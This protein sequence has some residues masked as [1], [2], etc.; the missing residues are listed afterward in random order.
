MNDEKRTPK[1]R[2]ND[3]IDEDLPE[4]DEEVAE[5]REE[6][7]AGEEEYDAGDGGEEEEYDEEPEPGEKK[8]HKSGFVAVVGLPNA[9]KST[10]VNRFL[11]E[12]ITIVSPKPQT[13]RSNVTCILSGD[14]YQVIFVDTPGIL[15]PRYR[16]QE[17]MS[18]YITAA[19]KDSDLLLLII[20]ASRYAGELPPP[21]VG[22]SEE[23]KGKKIVLAL[24]KIDLIPQ[25]EMLLALIQKVSE[26]FPGAEIVP[27]SATL[28]E[29]TDELFQVILRYLPEGPSY[30]PEDTIS[31]E[32]E[33][34]F[35]SEFIREAIF[36][37]MEEEIP[38]STAVII[39]GYE[40]KP[41]SVVITA[42]IMV[43]KDSQKPIIIGK[44]GAAIKEIGTKARLAIEEFLGVKVYLDLHVKVRKD[45]RKKDV[46]LR[47]IGLLRR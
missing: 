42:S 43:E 31:N 17:V 13:T 44:K 12:K 37:T 9:G 15:K 20:D 10:L 18:S 45:W 29:G 34:F 1:A 40:E 8:S 28:G 14:D 24:N 41:A 23:V 3:E 6:E 46:F 38:Y 25:K 5:D 2:E 36:L 4:A 11:R 47:E 30:F 39:E 19:V 33:R 27:I 21:L 16:M 32:S 7:A 35:A 22:F 26:L